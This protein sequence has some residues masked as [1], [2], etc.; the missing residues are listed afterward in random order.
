MASS[1]LLLG[2]LALSFAATAFV[3]GCADDDGPPPTG[4]GA[5]GRPLRILSLA[6]NLTEILFAMGLGSQIVGRSTHCHHPPEAKNI[7]AVGDTLHLDLATVIRAEPTLAFLVTRRTA[8]V[9]RL[10]GL[11]IRAVPVEADRMD[12]LREAIRT[13]GD[14]AGHPAAARSLLARIDTDLAAVR[15]RVASLPRPR[16]LFAF[17][18]TVGSSQIMVAGRGSFVDDL[19]AVAGAENAYPERADW[20][21]IGPAQVVRLRPEIVII[22]I[23]TPGPADRQDVIRRAWE[24]LTSVPAVEAGRIHILTEPYLTIP[25]PRVGQAARLLAETIH[26]NLANEEPDH[27]GVTGAGMPGATGGLPTSAPVAAGAEP[28]RAAPAKEPLP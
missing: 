16:T 25:G 2:L 11:G 28:P 1:R 21:S 13:I 19:L 7:P 12:Q 8:V 9:R 24:E 5:D 20:P 26:P 23:A 10:E 4:A 27:P 17:P 6:P 18:M 22:N 15:R 3:G 14:E